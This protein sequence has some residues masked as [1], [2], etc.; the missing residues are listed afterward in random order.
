MIDKLKQGEALFAEGKINEAEKCFLDFLDLNPE[1]PEVLNNL[2][3]IHHIRGNFKEAENKFIRALEIKEDYPDALLNLADLYQKTKR[4]EEAAL[5]LEK[6][7]TIMDQD[8]NLL[9]QLGMI[10]LELDDSLKAQEVLVKSLKLNPDQDIVRQS[11]LELEKKNTSYKVSQKGIVKGDLILN[12]KTSRQNHIIKIS[13][14]CLPGLQS[15]LG[16]I[17]DF[18]KTKYEVRTCYSNISKDIESAVQWA[19]IV[20]IEWANELTVSL[21]NHQTL[22]DGKYTICRLH[23]YEAFT[24]FIGKINWRKISNIIFVSDHI[25]NIVLQNFPDILDTVKNIHTIP[26]GINFN[27]FLFKERDTGYNLAFAAHISYKKG[28][29]LL[30]HAF[31]ELVQKDEKYRLFIAG[32]FQDIRYKLYFDQMIKEMDLINNIQIDGWIKDMTQWLDDKHYIVSTSLLESQQLSI[33]EAMA[34][35]IKPIIHNFVGARTIYPEKYIWNT[36][37]EFVQMVSLNNYDSKEYRNFIRENYSSDRQ[38]IQIMKI[39]TDITKK[40]NNTDS[41]PSALT[42]TDNVTNLRLSLYEIENISNNPLISVIIPAYNSENNIKKAIESVMEQTYTCWELI[43]IDDGSTDQTQAV[44]EPYLNDNRIQ[45]FY[46]K[47]GG[48]A[49]ARNVGLEKANGSYI[50]W[51]DSDDYFAPTYLERAVSSLIQD[52]TILFVYPNLR[53]IDAKGNYLTSWRYKDYEIPSLI[54]DLFKTGHSVVPGVASTTARREIYDKL[55]KFD[56]AFKIATDYEFL[57]RIGQLTGH[58]KCLNEELYFYVQGTDNLTGNTEEKFRFCAQV[59]ERMLD[60]Y[61]IETL[62]PEIIAQKIDPNSLNLNVLFHIENIFNR[63]IYEKLPSGYIEPFLKLKEK[64][65]NKIQV[66]YNRMRDKKANLIKRLDK[67]QNFKNMPMSFSIIEEKIE[68]LKKKWSKRN[69][70]ENEKVLFHL[71]THGG[72]R[73]IMLQYAAVFK[74]L[75]A[76]IQFLHFKDRVNQRQIFSEF[77]PSILFS[78]TADTFINNLDLDFIND[79]KARN[80]LLR[81]IWAEPFKI[82]DGLHHITPEKAKLIE[83]GKIGDLFITATDES[84]LPEIYSEWA[85]EFGINVKSLPFAANPLIH[86]ALD[87]T[88]LFDI[89][90]IGSNSPSKFESI[91]TY[92]YPLLRKYNGIVLGDRWGGQEIM[93]PPE[94][95]NSFYTSIKIAP[96]I[97]QPFQRATGAD[98]NER[99]FVIPACGG[100]SITDNVSC[101][102]KYFK[103]DEIVIAEDLKEW[104]NLFEYFMNAPEE[105]RKYIINGRN[106]VMKDHTYF[107]RLCRLTDFFDSI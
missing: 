104:F 43:I 72:N 90:F 99:T 82:T 12:G 24:N 86:Y 71:T 59:M 36:I 8:Y 95:V 106:R 46:K 33:C 31:R 39:I 77:R 37:P 32:D 21:T 76:Q 66:Q 84:V 62:F 49:S 65:S 88:P 92:L 23:S 14:L 52:K 53:L 67:I 40:I 80:T 96:N 58:T 22:L 19:D 51:L 73:Y 25:K 74:Y 63:H 87:F 9:N 26:N 34:S 27:K 56:V 64:Y 81:I 105:R 6:S 75:G 2:G 20:W 107:D 1:D 11:L 47:N 93:V 102:K 69:Q 100:F 4:W 5:K 10:Y 28:P 61:S 17:V 94:N 78:A 35:G 103:P 45:Y 97:H 42:Y 29:M 68:N 98:C 54:S 91:R 101:I 30:L 89:G 55:G 13:V 70:I 16:D 60:K 48:E 41:L 83:S 79:Y 3:A 44:V 18:L 15:F 7:I 85:N 50:S 57:S 38:L